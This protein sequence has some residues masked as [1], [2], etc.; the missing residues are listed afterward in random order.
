MK[1]LMSTWDKWPLVKAL[2][3]RIAICENT[4]AF[5]LTL[6]RD[7]LSFENWRGGGGK[8][9]S[10]WGH[11]PPPSPPLAT[12][13]LRTTKISINVNDEQCDYM[14]RVVYV[15]GAARGKPGICPPP[16]G[17]RQALGRECT[18]QADQGENGNLQL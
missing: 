5:S 10:W 1:M 12:A 13:L 15:S 6:L 7:L 16:L 3:V 14:S 11:C 8:K 2:L 9:E 4:I 17:L 18:H